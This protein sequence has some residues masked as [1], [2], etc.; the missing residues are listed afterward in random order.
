MYH[1]KISDQFLICDSPTGYSEYRCD[2]VDRATMTDEY[3]FIFLAG[4]TGFP[5]RIAGVGSSVAAEAYEKIQ[6]LMGKAR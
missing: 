5:I 3:L 2:A 4:P 6:S 1:L